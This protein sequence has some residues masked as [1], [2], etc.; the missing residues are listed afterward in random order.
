MSDLVIVDAQP[1]SLASLASFALATDPPC[2]V[3]AFSLPDQALE[4]I[5]RQTPDLIIARCILADMPGE[6]FIRRCRDLP[7]ARDVTILIIADADDGDLHT[8]ALDAGTT[9]VLR[10]PVDGDEFRTSVRSLLALGRLQRSPPA[11][12]PPTAREGDERFRRYQGNDMMNDGKQR[13][14]KDRQANIMKGK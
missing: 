9:D 6:E 8:R 11:D 3:H 14:H 12:V 10:S 2:A 1:A 5:A 4:F 7:G 13:N